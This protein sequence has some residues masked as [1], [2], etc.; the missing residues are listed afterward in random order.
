MRKL[1]ILIF[2]LSFVQLFAQ[3]KNI[4][5]GRIVM[6]DSIP[7]SDVHVQNLHNKKF[8]TTDKE[9]YFTISASESNALQFTHVSLQTTHRLLK[10]TDFGTVVVIKMRTLIH[11]LE[12]VE[13]QKAPDITA[14]SLGILQHTPTQRT[15]N[16]KQ[17][18]TSRAGGFGFIA[19][20]NKISGRTKMLRKVLMNEQNLKV[21]NYIIDNMSEFLKKELNLDEEEIRY[22]AYYL[23][24]NP[25]YHRVTQNKESKTLQFMLIDSWLQIQQEANNESE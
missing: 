25:E 23:M 20:L 11:E 6:N 17:L 19:L 24:E 21:A 7:V 8:T 16:E 12:G 4:F 22:L 3:N 13:V 10:A 5:H 15:Y 2:I 18:Y 1:Y 14:Q 9:G